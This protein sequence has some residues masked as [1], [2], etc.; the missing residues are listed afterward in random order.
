[1]KILTD[2][3]LAL[4]KVSTTGLSAATIGDSTRIQ[5]GET[6]IAI[7]S[8]LGTYTET[9]TQGIVSGLGREVTV[10]DEAT[11]QRTTLKNL[12]QTDAAITPATAGD[13]C[14]T[15]P[16]RSSASTPR[17]HERTGPRLRDPIGDASSLIAIAMAGKGA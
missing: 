14:S 8:P 1:V 2:N 16:E 5:V 11:R 13:R 17:V 9:V 15:P 10:A 7:G 3:D 4:V 6:A 12:I